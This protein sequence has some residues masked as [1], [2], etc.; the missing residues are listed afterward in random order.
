MDIDKIKS[1]IKKFPGILDIH[2]FYVW[3]ISLEE[4]ALMTHVSCTSKL[5]KSKFYKKFEN[6]MKKNDIKFYTVQ[7]EDSKENLY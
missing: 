2:G 5:N 3:S 1:T 4:H 7:L 6:L